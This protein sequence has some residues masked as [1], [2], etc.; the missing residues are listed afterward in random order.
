MKFTPCKKAAA[1]LCAAVSAFSVMHPAMPA[2]VNAAD[3]FD[4]LVLGDSISARYGM[5]GSDYCFQDYLRDCTGATS[6]K[7]CAVSGANTADLLTFVQDSANK[8]AIA[9]AEMIVISIGGND[10]LNPIREYIAK[11]VGTDTQSIK[12]YVMDVAK[13]GESAAQDLMFK[14]TSL[15][16]PARNAAAENLE[17]INNTLRSLNSN[18]KIVFQT[19]YNPLERASAE[20]KG[21]DYTN[22][23]QYLTNYIRGQLKQFNGKI[24]ALSNII[25][26]D[27]CAA[28]R[29][30]GWIFT[31]S[32]TN[33]IHPNALGHALIAGTI[34]DSAGYENAT[35]KQFKTVLHS[36]K[37]E[38]PFYLIESARKVLLRHAGIKVTHAFGDLNF[39]SKM[40]AKDTMMILKYV[41]ECYTLELEPEE[42]TYNLNEEQLELGDVNGDGSLNASDAIYILRYSNLVYVLDE[43]GVT[44]EGLRPHVAE[45]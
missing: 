1:M 12:D 21:K 10:L 39:D 14:F 18:A 42:L 45:E 36:K 31:F 30:D 5:T 26:A 32:E 22:E 15:L 38:K 37:T 17:A 8:T 27:V 29:T 13:Q 2:S 33:D 34:L 11:N 41:N 25:V 3:N 6:V 35:C 43:E 19:V 24:S 28:F 23:Y 7:D 40:D 16:R 9:N 20:Y 44:L 4:I